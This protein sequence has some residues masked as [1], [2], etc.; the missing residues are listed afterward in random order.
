[1]L[2]Q[3]SERL[4]NAA[5]ERSVGISDALLDGNQ[6][7][8]KS[9]HTRSKIKP[10][11]AISLPNCSLCDRILLFRTLSQSAALETNFPFII[12]IYGERVHIYMHTMEQLA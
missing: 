9:N 10:A 2:R 4:E 8:R 3:K 7:L 6:V 11:A 12:I 5:A 1:M